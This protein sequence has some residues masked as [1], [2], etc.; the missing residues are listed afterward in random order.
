MI[1]QGKET[2]RS[3]TNRS[4]R[5]WSEYLW[6][7]L[8]SVIFA[9]PLHFAVTRFVSDIKAGNKVLELGSGYPWYEI[10]AG[11]VG[12]KG[13]FVALDNNLPIQKR[14]RFI[15]RF[16]DEFMRHKQEPTV[17]H[18]AA[19]SEHLPFRKKSFDLVLVNNGPFLGDEVFRVLK[20]GGKLLVAMTEMPIPVISLTNLANLKN[21][22]FVDGKIFPGFVAAMHPSYPLISIWNWYTSAKKPGT[23]KVDKN[24]KNTRKSNIRR[25]QKHR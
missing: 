13:A 2:L 1:N 10:Y 24:Q 3:V 12:D 17:D 6:P 14:S 16:I 20:P 5:I 15:S 25:T 18:L 11:K 4:L 23:E 8:S 19:S 22:G 7:V 9:R 21:Y